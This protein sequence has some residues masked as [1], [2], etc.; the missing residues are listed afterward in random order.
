MASRLAP[1]DLPAGVAAAATLLIVLVIGVTPWLA[2]PLAVATYLGAGLLRPRR[3]P[4]GAVSDEARQQRLAYQAALANA[5]A[6]RAL[7]PR[8][9]KPAVREQV[10]RILDRIDRSL[11]VMCDDGDL[12]AASVLDDR[13]LEPFKALLAEYVRLA[14][15]GVRSADALLERIETHRLPQIEQAIDAF[16]ERLHRRQVIDLAT[17]GEVI[18]LNVE[19]IRATP[20]RRVTP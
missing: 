17:L 13:L 16:Y 9:A 10:G 15:R 11:R 14:S 20:P 19:S 1:G 12:A 18:E 3:Q 2:I 5:S 8:I 4:G 6:I 7:V